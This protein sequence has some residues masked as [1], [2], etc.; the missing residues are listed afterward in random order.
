M[1]R[2]LPIKLRLILSGV[3]SIIAVVVTAGV[4]VFGLMNSNRG[5]EHQII[6]TAAIQEALLTDMMHDAISGDVVS[7]IITG[8]QGTAAEK[9]AL[10]TGLDEHIKTMND[11]IASLQALDLPVEVRDALKAALPSITDYQKTAQSTLKQALVDGTAGQSALSAFRVKFEALEGR[12]GR[13]GDLIRELGEST[14]Q[15]AQGMNRFLFIAVLVVS[16]ITCAGMSYMAWDTTRRVT[17]PID[18]LREALK[19][20]AEGDFSVRI[21]NVTRDDDIGAIARDIDR[22]SDRIKASADEQT[23]MRTEGD[24][25]IRQLGVGLRHLAA[26]KLSETLDEPFAAEYEPLRQDFNDTVEKLSLVIAQV[27]E[28]SE[29]IR[30]RSSDISRASEDLSTRTEN[31]AATL[32]E[33]AAALE[34]LT[35]SV[36]AAAG[37]AKEVEAV[38]LKARRDV[39][40]SGRVVQGAVQAMTEIEASSSQISEII[41]VIDDISFQTNLLALNAGVEAARAGEAGRGFAVVASEVRALAQRSSVAAKEIKALIGASSQ[42]VQ[43]G[44]RHVDGAGAALLVVVDQVAQISRLVSDMAAGT[45]TQAQGLSEINIGVSQMDQVTQRNAAMA[46][47]SCEATLALNND[48]VGMSALVGQFSLKSARGRSSTMSAQRAEAGSLR[49]VYARSA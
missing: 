34:E 28:T 2:T 11:A 33:T 9:Q 18:R 44:V 17:K 40:E 1:F 27:V 15:K 32:E 12:L 45:L 31:Q 26:G 48:A 43:A 23:A 10:Q 35:S 7:S 30:S 25:I 5:L 47:E 6:A 36:S 21:G 46:Q 3:V 37:S 19:Q 24:R 39:E 49:P 41:G 16:V 14:T 4:G 42:H 22:V 29:S 38:V 20:V 13:F 8:P